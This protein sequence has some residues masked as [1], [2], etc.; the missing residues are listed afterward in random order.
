MPEFCNVN[1]FP[2]D[3]DFEEAVSEFL[4]MN[5]YNTFLSPDY[6]LRFSQRQRDTICQQVLAHEKT[7]EI[8]KIHVPLPRLLVCSTCSGRFQFRFLN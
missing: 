1:G 2:N 7:R 5:P 6:W 8:L 4:L 3:T